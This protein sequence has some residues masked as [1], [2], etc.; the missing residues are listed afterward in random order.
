MSCFVYPD[1]PVV[2]VIPDFLPL[3]GAENPQNRPRGRRLQRR[4]GG[5][6]E[7]K[8]ANHARGYNQRS[9]GI[10]LAGIGG[11]FIREAKSK[12][13]TKAD[14]A[15]TKKQYEALNGLVTDIKKRHE[16]AKAVLHSDIGGKEKD[17]PGPNFDRSK[18]TE[19][20]EWAKEAKKK[21]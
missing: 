11:G 2:I 16:K 1:Y 6:E 18:V 5:K 14:L 8:K 17:D 10:E 7:A 4:F 20:I 19:K 12:G 15:Y 21:R 13:A 9:I 3:F